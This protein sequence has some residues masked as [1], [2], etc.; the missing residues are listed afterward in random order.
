MVVTERVYTNVRPIKRLYGLS[1]SFI[2]AM[3]EQSD[4]SSTVSPPRTISESHP[5]EY[6]TELDENMWQP[7]Q[8]F[9]AP[10]STTGK[11]K[12]GLNFGLKWEEIIPAEQP[13]QATSATQNTASSV[14][15]AKQ[16]ILEVLNKRMGQAECGAPATTT[17]ESAV[18]DFDPFVPSEQIPA[19][20]A[21]TVS[22]ASSGPDVF[23]AKQELANVNQAGVHLRSRDQKCVFCPRGKCRHG[24]PV[25][26]YPTMKFTEAP[27]Q[28]EAGVNQPASSAIATDARTRRV[29]S[30]GDY[31]VIRPRK[32]IG[33]WDNYRKLY[34]E[35][36]MAVTDI[37]AAHSIAEPMSLVAGRVMALVAS[38]SMAYK[39]L[40][41]LNEVLNS[42]LKMVVTERVYTNVRPIK[43]LY[44]LS[45]SFISAMNEQ[46][47]GSSTVSP[48]RT[49]SESHPDEYGT[50]LDENMWQP[51]QQFVAPPSTT[52]KNKF[53][54]NFG[55][56][57]DEII[58]AKQP[59][60]A[61]SATQNT[62]SCVAQ[63]KKPIL[64]VLNKRMGQAECGAPATTTE[65]SAVRYFDPFVPSEQIPAAN[66][67]TVSEASSA[68]DVF[69]AKQVLANVDQAG[70]HLGS[71]DQK[72]VFCPRGKCRHG[73]PVTHYPTT[74][75]SEAPDQ[76]DASV[77]QPASSTIATGDRPRRVISAVDYGVIRP[78]KRFGMWDSYKKLYE[79]A[80]PA[81]TESAPAHNVA[82]PMS[83]VAGR[84][85]ALVA[86]DS[87]A[88]K[89]LQ[90]LN[91]ES[92]DVMLFELGPVGHQ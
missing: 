49:I 1:A 60:Q 32:P 56:K 83:L 38:D 54:L 39:I 2:S 78:R 58:P 23:A 31:G 82:E 65:E 79:K 48:P 90:I 52:D 40:Q 10:A 86:S 4:R 63:T 20:N 77:S 28:Q 35:T 26:H 34:E 69:A 91:E 30:A 14:A 12:Y 76:Q 92:K 45:A 67:E 87:T 88:Y 44:G 5:D 89:I 51:D 42:S 24:N 71:R 84:V 33:M 46:S 47:D 15:Q 62:A 68:P 55:L 13:P 29:I 73:N 66:A 85:M 22:E 59:S 43:R 19:A 21:E 50:E 25:T 37:D 8:Q 3:N 16:P 74:K 7:D 72:C 17:D 61:T 70:V 80:T 27:D 6:G 64:E 81:V 75:F 18:R 57:W 11:S 9:V 41:I 36:A 53:G